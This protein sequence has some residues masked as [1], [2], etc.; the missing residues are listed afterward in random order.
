MHNIFE[1]VTR[2]IFFVTDVRITS[3]IIRNDN[4]LFVACICPCIYLRMK[5]FPSVITFI[6]LFHNSLLHL[7]LAFIH[8]DPAY[9][10]SLAYID[11]NVLFNELLVHMTQLEKI[12]FCIETSCLCD[13]QM[14]SIIKSFQIRK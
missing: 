13:Q 7:D 9:R 12:N 5:Y 6:L 11:G 8:K 4:D 3:H 1:F 2:G 10:H 14:D